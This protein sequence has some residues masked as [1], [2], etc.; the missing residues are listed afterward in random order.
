MWEKNVIVK[1]EVHDVVI[2]SPEVIKGNLKRRS[3]ITIVKEA[4]VIIHSLKIK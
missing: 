2:T 1:D 4:D 3:N